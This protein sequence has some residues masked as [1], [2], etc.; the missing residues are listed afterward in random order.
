[1][2]LLTRRL[3]AGSVEQNNDTMFT[4]RTMSTALTTHD[5]T[6]ANVTDMDARNDFTSAMI[7]NTDDAASQT[8][9]KTI[10]GDDLGLPH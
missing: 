1:M 5:V 7:H 8:G 4:A 10:T 3:L 6:V 9:E 2:F